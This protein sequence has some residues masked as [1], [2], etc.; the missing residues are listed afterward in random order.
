[1]ATALNIRDIGEARKA[2]L[3]LEARSRGIS[4]AE[5]VRSFID[6]G[7]GQAQAGRDR[8]AE[9]ETDGGMG[10]TGILGV[11][12]AAGE[13]RVDGRSFLYRPEA[14]VGSQLGDFPVSDLRRGDT[15]M[16]AAIKSASA[17]CAVSVMHYLPV[18]GQVAGLSGNGRGFTVLGAEVELARGGSIEDGDG[19]PVPVSALEEGSKVA[20]SGLWE[21]TRIRATHVRI[22]DGRPRL[23][24]S[25]TG[26]LRVDGNG[27]SYIGASPRAAASPP[28][29]SPC[30]AAAC[31][32]RSASSWCCSSPSRSTWP[33]CR[34]T[35][36]SS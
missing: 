31:S 13:L 23:R 12:T 19:R 8:A 11:I 24:D 18:V 34:A 36:P 1:M 33:R 28:P 5:L 17:S 25:I 4:V 26:P 10:G 30:R 22:V 9:E 2:A 21:G 6:D 27:D 3:E 29:P 20:V 16:L 7:I 14:R 35:T 15:V 32:W